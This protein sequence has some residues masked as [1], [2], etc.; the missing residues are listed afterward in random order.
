[1]TKPRTA[2][3]ARDSRLVTWLAP[4]LA[5]TFAL[6]TLFSL[7]F[8][9]DGASTLFGDSDTGW[10]L[11][12][13]ENIISTGLLPHADPFSFSRPGQPW[14]A[15]EWGADVIMAA[16]CR[17]S[18]LGGVAL[19]YG[20]CIAASVWMW[21]RLNRAAG[22]NL[23]L[24]GLLFVPTLP[25]TTLHWLARPHIFSWLFLLGT[26]W[27]CE[28]MPRRLGWRRILF[29][30]IGSAVWC[31]LHASFFFAPLILLLYAAGEFLA[32]LV[33]TAT[34]G[35]SGDSAG[36]KYRCLSYRCLSY[37]G[38]ALA[39]GLGTL[40]NPNGWRLHQHVISYLSDPGL[41]DRIT[42][43]QSFDFHGE[44]ASRVMLVIFICFLGACAALDIHKPG[45]FLLSMLLITLALR[46][47]RAL[48]VA[49][50]LLVPLASGSITAVLSLAGGLRPAL[51]RILDGTLEYGDRLHLI[52]RRFRGFA[53]VPLA[54]VLIF[55]SIRTSAGFPPRDFPVAA[56][57]AVAKLPASA[58]IFATDTFGGYLIYRFKGERKVLVDGR[59]DFYG[60][61]FLDRYLLLMGVRPGWAEEF[62]RWNFTNALLPPDCA[63]LPA[64]ETSGWRELYRDHTAVLLAHSRL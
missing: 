59:S 43:F 22:G 38:L 29:V 56:S 57:A 42:E 6:V 51:R 41:I 16:V 17:V 32:P 1:M 62:N 27:M 18:G 11:R 20:L 12:N 9:F 45:R 19:M 64:L 54:A 60:T 24:A 21:F 10:H 58:R 46:S 33:W 40:A 44:G 37:V 2:E 50:L 7:F 39:A 53:I 55:V 28:Q 47:V 23:L 34:L 8:V 14:I 63:L 35:E 15:W 48:P 25:V 49:A 4:D 26:V 5:L 13:G 61:E 3:T 36:G 52:E 31:N 30:A